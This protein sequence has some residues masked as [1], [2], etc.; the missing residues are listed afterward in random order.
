LSALTCNDMVII[1]SVL[2]PRFVAKGVAV[3]ELPLARPFTILGDS[4]T[5]VGKI[6][7]R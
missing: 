6:S 7:N 3:L 1:C 5:A 2:A 4:G